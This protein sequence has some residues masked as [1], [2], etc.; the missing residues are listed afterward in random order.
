MTEGQARQLLDSVEEGEP[1]T[2][3]FGSAERKPW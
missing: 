2:V 3:T 1:R